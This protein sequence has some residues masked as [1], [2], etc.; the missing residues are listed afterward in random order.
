MERRQDIAA[1]DIA[2]NVRAQ[3]IPAKDYEKI[4]GAMTRAKAYGTV[5]FV[6]V[7]AVMCVIEPI[8][9]GFIAVP[10]VFAAIAP[11]G[12]REL[13]KEFSKEGFFLRDALAGIGGDVAMGI[14]RVFGLKPQGGNTVF[15]QQTTRML[16]D[17]IEFLHAGD[18]MP[19]DIAVGTPANANEPAEAAQP[20]KSAA[21]F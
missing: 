14:C 9:L 12:L 4:Y 21:G 17:K 10:V 15:T 2:A 3:D 1:Q 5:A 7:A 11:N 8:F 16:A 19:A 20:R 6:A 13:K 18:D